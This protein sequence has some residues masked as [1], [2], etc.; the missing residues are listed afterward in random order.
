M[1]FTVF[2]IF[3]RL[4]LALGAFAGFTDHELDARL[5]GYDT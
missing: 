3:A 5:V 1:Q 4:F 2:Q